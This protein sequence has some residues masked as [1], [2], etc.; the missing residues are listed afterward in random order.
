MLI[1]KKTSKGIDYLIKVLKEKSRTVTRAI[2]WKIPHTSTATEI[3][4]KIGR[5]KKKD[6]NVEELESIHPKS[7]LTLDH[8]EFL[9]LIFLLQEHYEPFKAGFK[10]YIPI[11]DNFD[12]SSIEHLR[13]LFNNPQK[14]KILD[15]VI[16]NNII[17]DDLLLALQ[18]INRKRA[19]DEFGKM[20][21]LNLPEP[22]WQKW[23]QANPW[24]LGT[25]F[26]RI[27]DDRHIDTNNISDYL[28]Q[29]YDGFLDII[30]IKRPEGNLKFWSDKKDHD[31]YIPAVELTKAII[32]ATKYIHAVELEA[33]SI[34]FL[35]RI[36]NVKTIKP[37]CVLIYGRSN[38][39]NDD[40]KEAYRLLNTS[41]HNLTIL[42]Y[43]HVL[44]RA[45][46][47]VGVEGDI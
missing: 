29:A 18:G 20:L 30:E 28:M 9:N 26:V 5:Y 16:K 23:F 22:N 15:F 38:N 6:F 39:W 17:P 40:Q 31:N 35:E 42:T 41:Y 36:G 1:S 3:E 21:E 45:K 8:E 44:Q 11:N 19:I 14:Q 47:I 13:A 34:K 27:L 43:D 37:R 12:H 46:R 33:N 7:E 32:Q 10:R 2:F 4:L 25:E 24:V